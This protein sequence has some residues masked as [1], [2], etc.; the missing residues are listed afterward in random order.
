MSSVISGEC[1]I[2][3]FDTS[4]TNMKIPVPAAAKLANATLI[5]ARTAVQD[6]TEE[7]RLFQESL[8][9]NEEAWLS[10]MGAG[11][12]LMVQPRQLRSI[13]I[14]KIVIDGVDQDGRRLRAI[15]HI[16]QINVALVAVPAENPTRI[17][18]GR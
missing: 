7:I 4:L 18:F 15:Q 13:G 14:D 6:V 3:P 9:E 12:G 8:G 2:D 16:T 17:G 11:G 10:M 1:A 5:A